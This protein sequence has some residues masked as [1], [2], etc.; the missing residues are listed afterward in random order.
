MKLKAFCHN[1]KKW[2]ESHCL[3]LDIQHI[4]VNV[5]LKSLSHFTLD[6]D[7]V[8]FQYKFFQYDICIYLLW[9]GQKY[10]MIIIG[11]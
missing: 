2:F 5:C 1:A 7:F 10:G 9:C 11:I 3:N 4:A 6:F 8:D